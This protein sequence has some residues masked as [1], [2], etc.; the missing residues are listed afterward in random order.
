MEARLGSYWNLVMPVRARVGLLPAGE[1]GGATG[2]WRYMQPPRLA[3]AR[4]RPRGRVRALRPRARRS[5]PPAPTRSTGSTS[6]RFLADR[7][8]ADQLVLSL[9]GTARGGDDARARSSPARRRA[10]RRSA[11]RPPRDVPAAERRAQRGVPRDAA[12]LLVHETASRRAPR[13]L[14]LALLDAARLA[15]AGQ[16]DRGRADADELR[17]GLVRDRGAATAS[18]QAT[19]ELPERAAPR[20]LKLRLRLPRGQ[21][22][23]A[24]SRCGRPYG[25]FDRATGTIDLSACAGLLRLRVE[26]VAQ[27]RELRPCA[28]SSS[29]PPRLRAVGRARGPKAAKRGSSSVPL[30]RCTTAASEVRALRAALAARPG[31][32]RWYGPK[33]PADPA[34]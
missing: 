27:V 24:R 1:R 18:S 30:P 16:A 34:R 31:R 2:V 8:E 26:L 7:G 5:R 25:R 20:T 9:Y 15:A 22:A 33:E 14:E 19:V 4:A 32:S 28:A 13:G 10:W 23:S 29:L 3:A 6:S 21:A 17:P 12:L 11:A